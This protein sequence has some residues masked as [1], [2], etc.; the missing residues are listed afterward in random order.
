MSATDIE[1]QET[2]RPERAVAIRRLETEITAGDGRTV[3]FRIAPF[4]E[5]AVSADGLGGVP[6]GVPYQEQLMP[7]LYD[8]QLRAANRV[9]LNFEHQQGIG[10]IVGHG[11]E[12]RKESD[13]YHASFRI[14]ENPDG[15]KTL[16][17]VKEGVL[18]GASV[19]S[20]WLKSIRSAS[21]VVQRVKAHLEAVA[22]CR[23]GAYPG[24]VLTGLRSGEIPDDILL[25]EELLPVSPNPDLL[26]RCRALGIR[27]PQRFQ[28]HPDV[29]DTPAGAGTSEDGTRQPEAN[30]ESSE[31]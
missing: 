9:L 28:A 24:A 18:R 12:L 20:Y 23:E 30:A 27:V 17:L 8:K 19:E 7:G 31:D 29:T 15:D 16:N 2:H 4:G 11:L 22:V 26:A 1:Q 25:D 10:G 6:R 14:H 13:G 5:V 21:G 3:S